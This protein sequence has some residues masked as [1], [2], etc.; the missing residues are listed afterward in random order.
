MEKLAVILV[1]TTV[2]ANCASNGKNLG[3]M[4]GQFEVLETKEKG[5]AVWYKIGDDQWVNSKDV[6][7]ADEDIQIQ[8]ATETDTTSNTNEEVQENEAMDQSEVEGAVSGSTTDVDLSEE[9]QSEDENTDAQPTA[10][11]QSEEN[12][13]ETDDVEDSAKGDEKSEADAEPK[14]DESEIQDLE[15]DL[16]DLNTRSDP[17]D[18]QIGRLYHCHGGLQYADSAGN[19][20][21]YIHPCLVT[22]TDIDERGLAPYKIHKCNGAGTLLKDGELGW[23]MQMQLNEI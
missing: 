21:A 14:M 23:V 9:V 7:V 6:T 19:G 22:V 3:A 4:S 11:I 8:T 2:R 18:C 12:S 17:V 1:E 15:D 20:G 13:S 10:S 5:D 16:E